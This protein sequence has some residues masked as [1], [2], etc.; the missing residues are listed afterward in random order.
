MF[1]SVAHTVKD[2]DRTV[3]AVG[4]FFRNG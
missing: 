1:V 3:E 4:E 2:I